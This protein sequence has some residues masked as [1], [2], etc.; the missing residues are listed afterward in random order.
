LRWP[1]L[2]V[3]LAVESSSDL[4]MLWML[5]HPGLYRAYFYTFW[6]SHGVVALIRFWIIGDVVRSFPGLGFV[7]SRIYFAAAAGSAAVAVTSGILCFAGK[8]SLP[9]EIVRTIVL[10]DR[11]TNIATA[12]FLA[13][14][15]GLAKL[16]GLGWDSRAVFVT[17]GLAVRVCDALTISEVFT[18]AHHNARAH[19]N[20]L[21]LIVTIAV[22]T[23]W[24]VAFR[25]SVKFYRIRLS[26]G[27]RTH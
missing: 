3:S 10:T 17:A 15:L 1:S 27:P 11:A 22:L 25:T 26:S 14:M 12:V 6:I 24:S 5:H 20:L 21:D 18:T 4:S 19:A 16:L 8:P 13:M 7:P 23:F 9:S 2:T